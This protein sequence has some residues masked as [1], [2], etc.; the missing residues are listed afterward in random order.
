MP[1]YLRSRLFWWRSRTA[2]KLHMKWVIFR[3]LYIHRLPRTE[4]MEWKKAIETMMNDPEIK[5]ELRRISLEIT[6]R[7]RG[8]GHD[9]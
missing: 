1:L 3:A 7:N 5:A 6:N 2:N 4:I 8:A 9:E